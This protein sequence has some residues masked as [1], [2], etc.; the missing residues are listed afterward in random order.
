[1][2]IYTSGSKHFDVNFQPT[3]TATE[4]MI[5]FLGVLVAAGWTAVDFSDGTNPVAAGSA[6]LAQLEHT[7]A[8]QRVRAPSG[9]MELC[10]QRSSNDYSWRAY[11]ADDGFEI[12]GTITGLPSTAGTS[13]Q[14]I[15]TGGMYDSGGWGWATG[16]A[17]SYRWHMCADSVAGLTG[18]YYWHIFAIKSGGTTHRRAMF[19]PL[20]TG[21][22]PVEDVAPWAIVGGTNS[23]LVASSSWESYYKKGMG[24]EL[25]ATALSGSSQ[26]DYPSGGATNPYNGKQ[27]FSRISLRDTSG[28]DEQVKGNTLDLFWPLSPVG[29]L[30]EFST[31]NLTTAWGSSAQ[32]EPGALF[33]FSDILVPWPDNVVP[34][35]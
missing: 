15:G 16:S 7:S 14:W 27:D 1:M 11:M 8:W 29:V 30:P 25:Q 17:T 13:F 33:R 34:V 12:A 35:I 19:T 3:S 6:S 4:A 10:W 18:V 24:G 21:S 2:A 9:T 5:Q 31:I 32:G 26:Q 28:V 20:E 22:Y 23:T